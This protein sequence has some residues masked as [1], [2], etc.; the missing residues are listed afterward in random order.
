MPPKKYLAAGKKRSA[1][2]GVETERG[3]LTQEQKDQ[4]ISLFLRGFNQQAKDN[5]QE[6]KKEIDSLMQTAEKA[7]RVEL[8]KMPVAV[9]KMKRKDLLN[10]KTPSNRAL[11]YQIF[12]PYLQGGE[13]A[14]VV[15]AAV[16]ANDCSVEDIPNTRLVRNCS[17]RVKVTTIVEYKDEENVPAKKASQKV[18]KTKSLVSLA[19]GI[20]LK[21]NHSL[22]RSAC[23]TPNVRHFKAPTSDRTAANYKSAPRVSRRLPQ[24]AVSRTVPVKEK[25][26][27]MSLRSN[28]VPREKAVP[29]V[30]IPLADGKTL[31]S[32]GEDLRNINVELL[33]DD[34]VQHIHNLVVDTLWE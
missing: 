30:N 1:D 34:T 15:A 19:S 16:V 3:A 11:Y 25:V 9:R 14:A 32:A 12:S 27:A 28:S 29:F 18:S 4:R 10:L 21:E 22:S 8:L 23:S 7:F 17:K 5:L 24:I 2:S 26:Q 13:E 33:N 31:C 20:H 6:M